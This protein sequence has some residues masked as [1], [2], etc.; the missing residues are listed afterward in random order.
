MSELQ[1][2]PL[3]G[4]PVVSAPRPGRAATRGEQTRGRLETVALWTQVVGLPLAILV[5]IFAGLSYARQ[6]H[7]T[8]RAV[9]AVQVQQH[10]LSEQQKEIKAL[11]GQLQASKS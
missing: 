11:L 4:K 2:P 8:Q 5:V 9:A 6:A 10:E 3:D 1:E 7:E